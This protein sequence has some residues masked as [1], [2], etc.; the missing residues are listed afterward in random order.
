MTSLHHNRRRAFSLIELTI[1]II[2]LGVISAI[3]IPRMIRG[4][5]NADV[6]G[7]TADLAVLRG[8]LEMCRYEQGSFPSDAAEFTTWLTTQANG[9]G[10]YIVKIPLLKTGVKKGEAGVAVTASNPPTAGDE[11]GGATGWLYNPTVGAVWA[12]DADHFDK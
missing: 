2:I 11:D 7:L 3:A 9:Y 5:D 6:T 12:N 10:P 8:A 1:V 4:A